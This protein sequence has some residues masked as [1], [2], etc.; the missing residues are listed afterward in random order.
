VSSLRLRHAQD[1]QL[2][3]KD[4]ISYIIRAR[5][6]KKLVLSSA[7]SIKP[8]KKE[9]HTHVKWSVLFS[10][11]LPFLRDPSISPLELPPPISRES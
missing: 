4:C 10:K 2:N 5:L 9:K 11:F 3:L 8:K 6:S 7:K 1:W